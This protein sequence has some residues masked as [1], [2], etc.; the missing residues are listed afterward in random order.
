MNATSSSSTTG[1]VKESSCEAGQ[2]FAVC[3]WN[4]GLHVFVSISGQGISTLVTILRGAG[5]RS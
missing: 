2:T 3:R 5:G 1:T 4:T